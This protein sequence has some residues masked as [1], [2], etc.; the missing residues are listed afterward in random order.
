MK[1][2]KKTSPIK[3]AMVEDD[4]DFR[5]LARAWLAPQCEVV[6][7]SDGRDAVEQLAEIEPDVILMDIALPGPDGVQLCRKIKAERALAEVPIVFVTGMDDDA[8]FAR[9][10]EAGG[11]AFVR[12]PVSSQALI[13]R[14][15]Q[16]VAP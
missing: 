16:L 2:R 13:S 5:A 6:T 12:K 7:L 3:V 9:I 14:I 15:R 8:T 4:A 11:A 10:I 1:R